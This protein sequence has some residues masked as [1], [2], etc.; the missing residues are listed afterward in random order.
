M[1]PEHIAVCSR[2]TVK[3]FL[4]RG[5]VEECLLL[6]S[7]FSATSLRF[8]IFGEIFAYVTDF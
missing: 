3:G 5:S 6:F 7:V 1:D 2:Y 8:T 4:L